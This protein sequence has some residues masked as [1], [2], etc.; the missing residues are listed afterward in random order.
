MEKN[1]ENKAALDK[2]KSLAEEIKI[3]MLAT[4]DTSNNLYGRPMT[5]MEIE[6]NGTIWFFTADNTQTAQQ[7]AKQSEVCLNYAHPGRN[8]YLTVQGK[9]ELV[10]DKEKMKQLWTPMLKIWFPD[11]VD[12][13]SIALLKVTPTQAH[14]WDSDASRV[15]LLFSWIKA[16]ITGDGSGMEG[17]Q[18]ELR[19]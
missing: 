19:I 14:Y 16:N 2:L 8:A 6:D 15:S 3:C 1:L 13:P 9:A 17:K 11:G 5:T 10:N 18:G 4:S 12:D 7:A